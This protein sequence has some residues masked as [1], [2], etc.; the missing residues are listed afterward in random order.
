MS[1]KSGLVS[2]IKSMCPQCRS[3][4]L[5]QHG[6]YHPKFLTM[7]KTCSNCGLQYEREPGFFYGAMYISY[8]L[9]V[10]IFLVVGGLVYWIGSN[11]DLWVYLTSVFAVSIILYPINFRLSRTLFLHLFS[12]MKYD[13]E[14]AK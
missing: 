9:S 11:P 4:K 10:G 14:K 2:V 7:N 8:M 13:P 1:E 12:G 3:E 6:P 5:F